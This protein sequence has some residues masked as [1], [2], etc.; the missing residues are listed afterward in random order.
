MLLN[1]PGHAE[2]KKIAVLNPKGGSGKTTLAVNIASYFASTGQ[3]AALMDFDPQASAMRWA[4][5]RPAGKPFIYSVAAFEHNPKMTRSFQLRMPPDVRYLVADTPAAMNAQRLVQFTRG[6]HAILVPV[7]PSDM[8]IHSVSRLIADLLLIAK[9]SRRMGR[10]GVVAN[11]VRENTL[12][13]RKLLLFLNS[14]QIPIVGILRDSQ[15]Y[16]HATEN[17]IGIHEVAPSTA[18]KDLDTWNPLIG[19]VRERL[20]TP[21]TPRDLMSPLAAVGRSVTPRAPSSQPAAAAAAV[22][23]DQAGSVEPQPVRARGPAS[24]KS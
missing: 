2:L 11:R 21:L 9:V 7:L 15:S 20:D 13:Y 18:R 5:R 22:R 24:R 12:A 19:W 14:L 3:R 1:I 4:H 23:P 16:V 6:V 8:D 17:G 10:L